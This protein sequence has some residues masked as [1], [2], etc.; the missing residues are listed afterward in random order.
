MNL[1]KLSYKPVRWALL[2]M[3]AFGIDLRRFRSSVRAFP[4][5]LKEYGHLRRKNEESGR[6]WNVR[7]TFPCLQDR[8]EPNGS[9]D[10][11]YLHQDLLVARRVFQRNPENHVDVGSS[12]GGFVSHVATFRPIEVFDIRPRTSPVHNMTFRVCDLMN[13]PQELKNYCDS[14]SCLHALEHFGLG[15]YGDPIDLFGYARGFTGLYEMLKPGG[16]LYL[17]FPVGRFERVEFNAHRVFSIKTV[18]EWAGGRFELLDFSYVDDRGDL[19]ESVKLNQNNIDTSFGLAYGC[20]IFEFR[21]TLPGV[22]E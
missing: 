14:L 12:I 3:S 18:L 6:P 11:Q 5:V 20:G 16:T 21:K 13:P 1:L 17:S 7:F 4:A 9:I 10:S 8:Y 2:W 19:H 15:R 22:S